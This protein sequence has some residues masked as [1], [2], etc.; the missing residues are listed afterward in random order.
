MKEFYK[1]TSEVVNLEHL[2]LDT[3]KTHPDGFRSGLVNG[4]RYLE[5]YLTPV[6]STVL[7][8]NPVQLK[9]ALLC[10]LRCIKQLHSLG[11]FHTDIRWLNV[12][13]Y[14]SSW[15]LIDCYDFCAQTDH[16]RLVAIKRQR[17]AGVAEDAEWCATDDLLQVMALARAEEFRGD[18][19]H[20]FKPVHEF[21][22]QVV[23]GDASVDDVIEL[24]SR[25]TL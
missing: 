8:S 11:Y 20:M 22:H 14:E 21:V 3:G 24:I 18:E 4:V 25:I 17:T 1:A 12:V 13:K 16:D 23:A 9:A 10:I 19:Y 2:F 5:I 15:I 7:P 6:G